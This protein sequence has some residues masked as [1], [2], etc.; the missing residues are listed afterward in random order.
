MAARHRQRDKARRREGIPCGE[1]AGRARLVTGDV[2]YP[3][4]RDLRGRCFWRCEDCGAHVGCHRGG[5]MPLGSP[6]SAETRAARRQ[7]HEV[8]DA[9]WWA[10][11]ERDGVPKSVARTAG[12]QWL[13]EQLG[14]PPELTHIGMFDA[15][16]ARRVVE[17]CEPFHRGR[18]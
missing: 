4:R 6:A 10:K 18:A 3:H 2:V 15:A 12:Y 5:S 8:F 9:L 1:C 17:L 13:S 7:A 14:L 16:T 11:V